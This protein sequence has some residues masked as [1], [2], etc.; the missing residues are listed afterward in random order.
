MS[1]DELNPS[2]AVLITYHNEQNLLTE[3]LQ[4]IANQTVKPSEILVYDDAST[5]RAS[6]FIPTGLPV[7]ITRVE[8][9]TGPSVGRNELLSCSQS[10]YIHFHD[11]DDLFQPEWCQLVKEKLQ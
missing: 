2:L 3:C 1:A 11:A 7:K 10:D 8:V 9:T 6:E 4:S 5:E